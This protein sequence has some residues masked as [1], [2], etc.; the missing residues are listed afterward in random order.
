MYGNRFFSPDTNP[1]YPIL[2]DPVFINNAFYPGGVP[3]YT[4][5]PGST[6]YDAFFRLHGPRFDV[7]ESTTSAPMLHPPA[8]PWSTS[9]LPPWPPIN[10]T[11]K[12]TCKF[13]RCHPFRGSHRI[14]INFPKRN[15]A[16]L[17]VAAPRPESWRTDYVLPGRPTICS[18]LSQLKERLNDDIRY[19]K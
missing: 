4:Q 9:F 1:P 11:E 15:K 8:S 10:G 16:R 13:R 6:D 18:W 19:G 3:P 12:S 5:S 2:G 14:H 7:S 17:Q